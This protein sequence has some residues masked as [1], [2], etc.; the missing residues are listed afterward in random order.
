M[1]LQDNK[2]QKELVKSILYFPSTP[3]PSP[4]LLLMYYKVTHKQQ[5]AEARK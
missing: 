3:W 1:A 2:I 5:P 4:N